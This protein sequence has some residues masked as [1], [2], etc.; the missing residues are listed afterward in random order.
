L[1]TL[2]SSAIHHD[3]PPS[4]SNR[5]T[6]WD[7]F[8][9]LIHH[10]LLL[11]IPL[12]TPADVEA[13]AQ[14]FTATV[15]WAGWQ[16]TPTLPA[17]PRIHGC[18]I[19]IK[20]KLA[21]KRKLRRDWHR[22][23]T[24]ASKRLLNTA[25]QDLKQLIRRIKNDRVQSYLQEF[26]PT[27]AADYSLW[28]ATKPLKRI[29]QPSPSIRTPLGTWASSN[30]DKAHA[31]AH[32]LEEVFQPHPSENLPEEEEAITPFLETPYQLEPP[33]PRVR[34]TE[35]QAIISSLHP[36]KSSRYDLITG[37]ILQ[38]LPSIAIQFLTQLF[39][40]A[41][42]LGYFPAQWKI[43]Q[44]I[45]LLKPGKPPH[46][47]TSYRPISLLPVVSKV[48]EKLLNRIL[49][50]VASHSLIPAHQFGFR[51][52]HSTIE[53]THRVVQR[54][55]EAL[56]TKQYWSAAFL[57]ISQ[58]CDKVW[59]T[60]LLYKLRRA[61]PFNYFLLLKSYILRRHFVVKVGTDHSPL[62]SISA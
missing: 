15:Q 61:L 53:Q 36:K 55:Q 34:C 27:A 23:R 10:Q 57:D 48:F 32:H 20:Q 9:H 35:V 18:P 30:S 29:T 41:L 45:L 33:I 59:H 40:A 31:F 43:A 60:G 19:I 14:L 49:P 47:I 17:A 11:R 28:K 3:P 5:S 56:E 12:Q 62:T 58:A 4:L 25:T 46:D 52:R 54:I 26:Q 42:L 1:V 39:N 38:A 37:R 16:A 22:F 13:A 44:I 6:D 8:S 2:T 21:E 50:L 7:Y 51:K 24:P